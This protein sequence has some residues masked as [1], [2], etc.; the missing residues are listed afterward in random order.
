[1]VELV[2]SVLLDALAETLLIKP[3]GWPRRGGGLALKSLPL[4]Y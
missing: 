4:H 1:M 3:N 2:V